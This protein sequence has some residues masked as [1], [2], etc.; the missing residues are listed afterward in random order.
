MTELVTVF[1][2]M[3]FSTSDMFEAGRINGIYQNEAACETAKT[4]HEKCPYDV[5]GDVAYTIRYA[6][7]GMDM[8]R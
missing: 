5:H 8:H 6:C 1:V 7:L 2:L 3:S 4:E